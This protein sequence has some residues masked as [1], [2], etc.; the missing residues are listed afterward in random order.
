M[1]VF[2]KIYKIQIFTPQNYSFSQIWTL[3]FFQ[4]REQYLVQHPGQTIRPTTIKFGMHLPK[5]N[6][7]GRFLEFFR[8]SIFFP[9]KM[10]F[11]ELG[12]RKITA[13]RR[14]TLVQHQ[15]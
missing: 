4:T 9:K 11:R 14:Q 7:Y 6:P 2:S 5:G 3:I 15:R 1:D 10:S 8:N 13:T 12:L